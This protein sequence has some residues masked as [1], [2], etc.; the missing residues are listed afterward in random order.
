MS[1]LGR[2]F[3]SGTSA[4]GILA[5]LGHLAIVAE[6]SETDTRNTGGFGAKA[7]RSRGRRPI[8]PDQCHRS[9]S[10]YLA[11]AGGMR[12]GFRGRFFPT[13]RS[14][15]A[16]DSIQ[17]LPCSDPGRGPDGMRGA[18][19]QPGHWP[20][21]PVGLSLGWR[22]SAGGCDAQTRRTKRPVRGIE[23]PDVQTRQGRHRLFSRQWATQRLVRNTV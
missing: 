17:P 6:R 11:V 4:S 3:A 18:P 7:D 2:L 1:I 5:G 22:D 10:S 20:Q 21:G 16:R 23:D 14:S 9:R 12:V 8:V 19:R 13:D 15:G